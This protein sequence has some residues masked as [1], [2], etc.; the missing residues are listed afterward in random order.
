MQS[1]RTLICFEYCH[2]HD[3]WGSV[4]GFSTVFQE[5]KVVL[6][7]VENCCSALSYYENGSMYNESN[8]PWLRS[9]KRRLAWV[10]A[11]KCFRQAIAWRAYYV[12]MRAAKTRRSDSM[13]ARLHYMCYNIYIYQKKFR[14]S[15]FVMRIHMLIHVKRQTRLAGQS[16]EDVSWVAVRAC[17]NVCCV[18]PWPWPWP[19]LWLCCIVTVTVTVTV[20]H[21]WPWPWQC[22]IVTVTVTVTTASD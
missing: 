21:S 8:V 2:S 3:I 17:A 10:C 16:V 13:S 15:R 9:H 14:G 18:A 12:G 20:L 5:E 4:S 7:S 19:W 22:C 6:E 11:K 1:S